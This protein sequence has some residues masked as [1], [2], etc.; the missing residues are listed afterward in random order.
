MR[1]DPFWKALAAACNSSLENFETKREQSIDDDCSRFKKQLIEALTGTLKHTKPLK[2]TLNA[3]IKYNAT[4]KE[5]KK[6]R[7]RLFC[8][9]K[10][11]RERERREKL[12]QEVV[13]ISKRLKQQT[14]KTINR[15]KREQTE[16]I[17]GLERDDC[18]RMWKELKDLAGWT[19]KEGISETMFDEKKQ[20]VSGEK[21]LEVWK[22]AFRVLG[23][24]D[25]HDT[26]YDIQ[27]SKEIVGQ[28]EEIYEHSFDTRHFSYHLDTPISLEETV[29][30][31]GRLKLG[32]AAGSDGV[33]AEIL[34]RGGDR[35]GEA[36]H[37]LCQKAWEEEKLPLDWTRGVVVPI[38]KDGE[39]RD[40]L[41]YRGITLLSIVGKVYTQIINERL[42]RYCEKNK[43]LVEEQG[44]FRPHRGCPDQLFALVEIIQNRGKKGTFCCFIDVKKAFDRVFRAGLLH[45]VA[46][47]GIRGKMWRV[48]RSI[49]QTVDSCV[50]IGDT[51]TEWFSLETGVRQGCVLSPLLYALFINGLVKE[52]QNLNR[53]VEIEEGNI[54]NSL[55]YA[56]DI[57]LMAENRYQ[58][59]E[60]L[61]TVSSYAKRWRFE[62]NPKKSEV[63]VFG[64]KR[65]PRDIQWR[66]G[67]SRIKQVTQ[68]KYLGIELTRT[69]RWTPYFKR[70]LAK[71]KRNMTQALAMGIRGGFMS[72]RLARIIW[73]SLVRSVIEYGNEIWGESEVVE[74][75]KIQLQMGKRILRCGS[76]TSEE[77]VRGELGWERQRARADEMRLRY[78]G[79]IVRMD[80]DRVVKR[81]YRESKTRLEKEESEAKYNEIEVTKTW[82]RY[83]KE[84]MCELHLESEWR[85]E[86]IP[87]EGEW[88]RLVRERIHDREQVKWR[89]KC[90]QKPKLR[91]YSKLKTTLRVEPY[92]E[93][94][95]RGG[96]PELAKLRGG[97]NR[98]R[99]E[100]G[101]YKKEVVEERKCL[102]C[103][104]G[105]VEDERH[106]MLSCSAYADLRSR[107]WKELE[108]ETEIREANLD[109]DEQRLNILIGETLQPTET[110]KRSTEK[111][112]STEK[113]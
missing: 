51:C 49:Y 104:S 52:L 97:T 41:N 17:E 13:R 44:G 102:V 16:E 66:L 82:C 53:G 100:Q 70:V 4:I 68:Y 81:I 21:V 9:V 103:V 84:L 96:I 48:L 63:V 60:M 12:K 28:Q 87:D 109:T 61:D 94:Y 105:E 11:E 15:H 93:V 35:V 7:Q 108:A 25:P 88:N 57:V 90:L 106:F 14:R 75:E 43:I 3:K 72:V 37:K 67:E 95:H 24:E 5:L 42:M 78:W 55:L 80:N 26:K 99:I 27:F 62:L 6:E 71:A 77:V 36:V 50:R 31:I 29:A 76:R 74:F 39:K 30:A 54:I 112:D 107:L 34:I 91:T 38:Y 45:R 19:S 20:E 47:E 1:K 18:R 33:V 101:R 79:K 23:I 85:T 10:R 92:L 65:A 69:L 111:Q 2:I 113:Q 73:M 64:L 32:K 58:L 110:E 83:T 8:E 59:Q 89:S 98:L 46:A 40:P 86:Q 56:D 22:E